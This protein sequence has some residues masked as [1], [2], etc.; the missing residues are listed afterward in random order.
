VLGSGVG[1]RNIRQRLHALYGDAASL[2]LSMGEDGWTHAELI[3]P[4]S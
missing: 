2:R 4:L 3:L 1:L